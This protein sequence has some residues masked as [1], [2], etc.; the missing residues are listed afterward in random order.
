MNEDLKSCSKC[1]IETL[2]ITFHKGNK[3]KDGLY[4]QCKVC[5]KQ[6]YTQN[7]VKTKNIT[8]IIEID[9]QTNKSFIMKKTEIE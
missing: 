1:K 3:Q 6:I 2:M 9:C 7:S 4:K 8:Y 5:R